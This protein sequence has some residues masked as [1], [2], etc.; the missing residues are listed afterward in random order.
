VN[1]AG[2][3]A[4][5]PLRSVKKPPKRKRIREMTP[6]DREYV[7]RTI[8]DGQFR[9]FIFV[10]LDTG[11]REPRVPRRDAAGARGAQDGREDLFEARVVYLSPAMQEL[12]KKLVA[13]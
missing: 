5:H 10:M 3:L 7:Y 4:E 12:T 2:L 9:E 8:R 1:E 13:L 11:C 6:G